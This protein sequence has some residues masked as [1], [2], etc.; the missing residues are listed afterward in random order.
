MAF[1]R[2]AMWMFVIAFVALLWTATRWMTTSSRY[3]KDAVSQQL[4]THPELKESDISLCMFCSGRI[5]TGGNKVFY[6]FTLV[7]ERGDR[8]EKVRIQGTAPRY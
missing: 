8:T 2:I 5:K 4:A 7:I 1:L 6:D 3:Y